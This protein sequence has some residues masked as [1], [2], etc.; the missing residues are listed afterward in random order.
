MLYYSETTAIAVTSTRVARLRW[1]VDSL[2]M[3]SAR[4]FFAS[5]LLFPLSRRLFVSSQ[6]VDD[7]HMYN[8]LCLLLNIL[9]KMAQLFVSLPRLLCDAIHFIVSSVREIKVPVVTEGV[10]VMARRFCRI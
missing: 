4:F 3:H 7:A 6:A 1:D 5:H 9:K 10:E 2:Q 8:I